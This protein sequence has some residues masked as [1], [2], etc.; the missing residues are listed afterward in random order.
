MEFETD[1]HGLWT[2]YGLCLTHVLF[3]ANFLIT[4]AFDDLLKSRSLYL[5][6]YFKLN[7]TI[8]EAKPCQKLIQY[9]RNP[10]LSK[11]NI[12]PVF[13]LQFL[14]KLNSPVHRYQ[15]DGPKE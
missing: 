14:S 5:L 8:F 15:T 11:A 13:N 3:I 12:V 1:V 4:H 10:P 6:V 9:L 7:Q 2:F